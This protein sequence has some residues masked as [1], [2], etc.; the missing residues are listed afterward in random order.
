MNTPWIASIS[1]FKDHC[2]GRIFQLEKLINQSNFQITENQ[3][4]EASPLLE[5]GAQNPDQVYRRALDAELEKVCSF[6]RLKEL[7]IYG[8][9]SSLLKDKELFENE[10]EGMG[11]DRSPS[12]TGGRGSSSRAGN[13]MQGSIFRSFGFGKPK[14]TSTL[15]VSI[16]ESDEEDVD[17]H[18]ALWRAKGRRRTWDADVQQSVEDMRSSGELSR[19]RR[20]MSQPWDYYVDQSFAALYHSGITLKK[21]AIS[22]YVSLCELKSFIQLN[23]TGFTKALKKYD[24]ILDRHIKT[25]YLEESVLTA[26]PFNQETMEH[27]EENIRKIEQAYADI[28]TEGNVELAKRELRL[29]LREHVVWE[30]NTVWREMIGIE[31]KSQAANL[32]LRQTLLG[33]DHPARA[34]LQGDDIDDY[35]TKELQTPLGKLYYPKWLFS[36]NFFILAGVVGIF[37]VLLKAPTLKNPEQKNCLAMLVFVSLLWATEVRFL[38]MRMHTYI[39][40]SIDTYFPVGYSTVCHLTSHTVSCG[41]SPSRTLG[42]QT[43]ST[44]RIQGGGKVYI[45]SYVD[46]SHHA[47]S[48]RLCNRSGTVEVSYCENVGYFRPQQSGYKAKDSLNNE[49]VCRDGCQHVDQ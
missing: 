9:V 36:L 12:P 7:E 10:T 41:Y 8:E 16:D 23:K 4:A 44:A 32:G 18:A 30:R 1:N 38:C 21:R 24:K 6:Y 14:R 15:S 17:E 47:T 13:Q 42:G 3:D 27:L 43:A 40:E 49:H 48:W 33:G 5:N 26:Y 20:R 19:A 22:L 39:P 28:V 34:R 2:A 11:S 35:G 29:N 25:S 46:T 45:R 37:I 31:R